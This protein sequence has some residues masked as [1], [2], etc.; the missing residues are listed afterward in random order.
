M[1]IDS[2]LGANLAAAG[3]VA[4]ELEEERFS[5]VWSAEAGTDPFLPLAVAASTTAHLALGT[6]IVVAFGRSPMTV[7][8]SANDLQ[9]A[10]G[11]RMMVGLGSQ[12]RPHIE[13]RYS[14]PWSHPAPR[15]RE[16]VQALR[17]IWAAWNEQAKLDFRGE[18]YTHTLMTPFFSPPAHDFGPPRVFLAAVG[19]AMTRVAAETCDGLLVHPFTTERALRELTLPAVEGVLAERGLDRSAFEITCSP[20]VVTGESDEAQRGSDRAARREIAFHASTPAYR[21]VLE[22]HGWGDMQPELN[23]LSKLGDWR[24]MTDSVTDEMLQAFAVVGTPDEIGPLLLERYA[25][26]ADRLAIHH[27]SAPRADWERTL[28]ASASVPTGT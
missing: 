7:A 19:P 9:R 11:G 27:G 20:M 5:G 14:M 10:S 13:R 22:L 28:A 1:R 18:Y 25:G 2:T 17:A 23:R 21:G 3:K 6:N 8:A 15:M 16:F 26:V 12:I 4:A 24:A